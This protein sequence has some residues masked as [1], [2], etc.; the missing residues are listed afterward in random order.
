MSYLLKI[1]G[2]KDLPPAQVTFSCDCGSSEFLNSE[3]ITMLGGGT[4]CCKRCGLVFYQD[5]SRLQSAVTV[6]VQ[7][8]HP[9]YYQVGP[10][11]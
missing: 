10:I 8:V 7:G 11:D 6:Y 9:Q 5:G 1:K 4:V 2:E 3:A